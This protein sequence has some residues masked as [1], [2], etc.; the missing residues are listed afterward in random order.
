MIQRAL[1]ISR[2]KNSSP[3]SY[4]NRHRHT[5]ITAIMATIVVRTRFSKNRLSAASTF[6]TA[7]TGHI[8]QIILKGNLTYDENLSQ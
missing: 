6:Y 2:L 4:L 5:Y 8:K 3:V 7:M 1:I